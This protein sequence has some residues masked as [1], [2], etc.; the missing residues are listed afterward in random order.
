MPFRADMERCPACGLV[1]AGKMHSGSPIYDAGLEKD[2][3]VE[4]K[5][6]L[7]RSC[8]ETLA[9]RA[10]SRGRLLDVGSAYGAFMGLAKIG[11]WDAEGVEIDPKM[12]SVSSAAGFKVYDRPLEELSLPAD[13]YNVITVFEVLCM[14]DA[15]VDAV[16]QMHRILAPKGSLYIRE[17]NGAFH[18]ALDGFW[19]FELLGLRPTIV[20]NFNFTAESLRRML[21]AAGFARVK[22]RNSPPTSG[23]PYRT[24]GRLGGLFTGLLKFLYYY[25]SQAVYFASFGR[26]FTGSSLI[27]TAR[28]WPSDGHRP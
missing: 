7:F 13:S 20:H 26:V 11:G 9:A 27:I 5:T 18:L 12:V 6:A 21:T 3:Y 28:K 1:W 4:G 24:G 16:A 2:I 22:I 23:D 10:P 8:L 25:L 17:F 14:M 19:L 15:P